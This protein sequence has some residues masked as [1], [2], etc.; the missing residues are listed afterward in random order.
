ML[1]KIHNYLEVK[2]AEVPA[3][4]ILVKINLCKLVESVNYPSNC[5]HMHAHTHTHTHTHTTCDF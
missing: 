5:K 4:R 3:N 2:S 1:D